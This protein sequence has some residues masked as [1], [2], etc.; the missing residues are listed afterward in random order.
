MVSGLV[1]RLCR[2]LC[3]G[4]FELLQAGDVWPG[5]LEPVEQVGQAAVDVVD[6][7]GGDL[8]RARHQPEPVL[9]AVAR[10]FSHPNTERPSSSGEP[11]RS[12]AMKASSD[13]P[14]AVR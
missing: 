3:I 14:V 11:L 4:A 9:A 8:H 6:V 7:E 13:G 12:P 1:D 2:K 5:G 10:S